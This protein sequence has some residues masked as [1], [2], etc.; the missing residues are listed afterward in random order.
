MATTT[1]TGVRGGHAKHGGISSSDG[2]PMTHRQIME[3]L[4]GLLL[5][6][7]VAILSSTVVSNALPEIISDL[8]GGQSAYTWVVTASL[9]AMT[10]TTPLWG[11]LSDLFSK[12]LLVQIALIIYVAG[13]VVAGLSTSSG[14]LIACRVVQGIGVGGL[15]ALAQI[16]MAAMI[17]PRE[18]GRYSGYLGA[19]FAVATVGGPLLGG[20]ITDTSWMG[21]RWC[22]YVGVPFAV[23][24]LIVLQKTLKLPVVKRE[25]KVDWTGAFFISAAVSLLLLWVTFAGDKYD[26]MSWQ[27]AAMLAGSAVLAALFVFTESRASEPIIPLRLFRNR[28]ITLASVASLFVGI[29]M[30]AGTVFFSQYFQLARGKS[31][32]MSGVMTIPMIAGLFLSST[33]S[34]QVITKTGRWKAW[35]VSGGFLVTAGL[36]MLGTIRYD[37]AYWHIAVFMFVMGLGIGMMMQNLVLATQNQVAPSDLGSASSVVTFFRSLGGAIGVSALGAVLGNRVTHYVKDGLAD[38]GPKGAALGH[39][40]TGGGGIPDLD[41]LPAPF[42]TVVESAYGHG[43]GDVFMYAAPAALIAFLITI[44]IKEVALKTNAANDA[45]AEAEV[46]AAVLAEVPSGAAALVAEGAAGVTSVDTLEA[47]AATV[48][49]TAVRGVVRGAEGVP[50]AGA[51]VTL[52]SLGGRQLGR[53]VAQ[54]DGSYGVQA[55]GSGSYVLIASADGFQPQASTVVVGDEQLSY[56]ILLV[57][58]SGLAGTVRAA[59]SGAPVDGAMVIVTDVRGDVL[60]T[61]KSAENG[62]FTF[63]ELVPGA[64]TVAVNAAG[65]RPMALPVEIGGQGVTRIDAALQSGALVQGVVR[66]GAALR[67]LPDARVTLVDA[68]GN[69]VATSTTGEDGAYAFADLDAGEYSVIA[70]GYPPVAGALTVAGRGVDGHDIELAHPGE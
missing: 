25:V 61:G 7:F 31:P 65:Y 51:A 70:T 4:T 21:W 67:P 43:V 66:A 10:A 68:A 55:P 49:G 38:L 48:P 57:G 24:A 40:G 22:F 9:L 45:P 1:P 37:T 15:S 17:A 28:T 35:L 8:G 27:T 16:V 23:I 47:P 42:R 41:K 29:A 20:V 11:K 39:G 34:G 53:S 5:G 63:A 56:D 2:A 58:T 69:V 33:I 62:E 18:R 19:V 54:A 14:M 60:A 30:F 52:I 46:P 26:W 44:F 13:S 36:G 50:V 32:T 64:V 59:E 12:K 3:A 6:M